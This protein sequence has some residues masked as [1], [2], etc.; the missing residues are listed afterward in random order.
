[1]GKRLRLTARIYN[2]TDMNLRIGQRVRFLH[3]SGDGVVIR[4]IDKHTVE[5]DMGDD[6][7]IDVSIDEIIPVDSAENHF[8]GKTEEKEALIEKRSRAVSQLGT[9]MLDVSL[10]VMAADGP[11]EEDR[12]SLLLVNPEPAD[13]L[14]TC[15]V[16]VGNRYQG[17]AA[18]RIDSGE[19]F[20]LFTV[21][22]SEL[23]RIKQIHFQLLSF[24]PG[25]GH[26]HMPLTVELPWHKGRMNQPP[27]FLPAVKQEGWAFSLREDKQA[28]DVKK[29]ADSEF[30]KIK[31]AEKPVQRQENVEVD[32]HIEEL[33]KNP[34]ALAPSEMLRIQLQH[35]EQALSQALTDNHQSMV[36][37]HGVGEGVL[38]KEVRKRLKGYPHV[39]SFED[40]DPKRYGNGA[41]H[42][43]FK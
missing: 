28:T 37:I 8:L 29:I 22:R 3:E 5:V 38:R 17:Q 36:I 21:P 23:N 12:Y 32:L 14:F 7:P 13:M 16:K 31:Q 43:I 35:L 2:F 40:G 1:M 27:A 18:G 26:P 42:V 39:K 41:T 33:V 24:V 25:Q 6:F 4:L 19:Y 30:I 34:T 10:V 15:Y 9:S 20:K 11:S